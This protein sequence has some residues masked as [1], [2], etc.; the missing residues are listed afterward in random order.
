MPQWSKAHLLFCEGPH[1]AAFVSHLLKLKLGFKQQRLKLSE[2]PYPIANVLRT[3]FQNRASEDL[4]LDLARRFFLPEYVLSSDSTLVLVFSYG[5][6]NRKGSMEPFLDAVFTLLAVTSF[7]SIEQQ[8]ERPV[9]AFTIFADADAR[10]ESGTRQLIGDEFSKVGEADWLSNAWVQIKATKAACQSSSFGPV[11][12]Y[13]WRKN[14]EDSGTLEDLLLECLDGDAD[15]ERTLE[16]L[17]SR[18]DWSPPEGA[19]PAQVC[20]HAASRLKAAFCVEGQR[21]KPGGS[22]AVILGQ[23][24]LVGPAELECSAAVQDC[25]AFLS[26]WLS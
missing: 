24:E 21:E 6:S 7:S 14:Q 13:I 20:G 26:E 9:Y 22:L 19:K 15:L 12:A 23:S 5:G 2:L 16:Y 11:A 4:R 18:F 25:V 17:D 10:G 3:S 1:D 8:A